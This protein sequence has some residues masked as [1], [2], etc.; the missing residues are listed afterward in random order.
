MKTAI[1]LALLLTAV[2]NGIARETNVDFDVR[3][4]ALSSEE[5]GAFQSTKFW[6][7]KA[8]V[9]HPGLSSN[10]IATIKGVFLIGKTTPDEAYTWFRKQDMA[11][12]TNSYQGCVSG[13]QYT[14]FMRKID[15][16]SWLVFFFGGSSNGLA[17][18]LRGERLHSVYLLRK[19]GKRRWIEDVFPIE[20]RYH[21]SLFKDGHPHEELP[22]D[23]DVTVE[24]DL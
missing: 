21:E 3:C 4:A 13:N 6:G 2:L 5:Q 12:A 16:D 9:S 19:E 17:Q 24:T 7:R 23:V 1:T 11:V 18:F 22:M 8:F 15:A 14:S 20:A 10:E